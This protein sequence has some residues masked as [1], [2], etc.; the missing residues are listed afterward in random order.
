[1][2]NLIMVVEE[3]EIYNDNVGQAVI[4]AHKHRSTIL[5]DKHEIMLSKHNGFDTQTQAVN[6]YYIHLRSNIKSLSTAFTNNFGEM[7]SINKN[8]V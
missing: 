1:M 3:T 6:P 8:L 5:N 7:T 2:R 4:H